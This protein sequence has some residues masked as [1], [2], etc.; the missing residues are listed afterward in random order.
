MKHSIAIAILLASAMLAAPVAAE[1]AVSPAAQVDSAT[2]ASTGAK[3]DLGTVMS[4][5]EA[6]RST[7][8][9]IQAMTTVGSVQIAKLS[10]IV[11]GSDKQALDKAV[12]DNEADITGVQ[13]AIMANSALKKQIDAQTVDTSAIVAAS[14]GADGAVT[15]F[16]R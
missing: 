1:D 6:S 13:A 11:S 8:T 7:A 10:D 2:T 12:S 9:A 3:A 5:I 15:V 16:V 4:S 14:I